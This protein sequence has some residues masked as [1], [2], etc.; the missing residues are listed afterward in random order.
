MASWLDTLEKVG[1]SNKNL[2]NI[3]IEVNSLDLF[4]LMVTGKGRKKLE[5]SISVTTTISDKWKV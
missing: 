1:K 5:N 3:F 4:S 2:E